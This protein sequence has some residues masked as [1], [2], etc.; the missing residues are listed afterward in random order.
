MLR[1]TTFHPLVYAP[2]GDEKA[3][4]CGVSMDEES[5][6]MDTTSK[7]GIVQSSVEDQGM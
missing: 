2:F 3:G 1:D 5:H 7:T 6:D 4:I